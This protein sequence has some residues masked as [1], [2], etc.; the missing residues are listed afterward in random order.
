MKQLGINCAS[1]QIGLFSNKKVA[2]V[3]DG[4]N[5]GIVRLRIKAQKLVLA[6]RVTR[7]FYNNL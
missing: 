1:D 6:L 3:A 2:C 7:D 5:P 4:Q